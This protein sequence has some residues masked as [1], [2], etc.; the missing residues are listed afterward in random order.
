MRMLRRRRTTS[1]SVLAA[2][3][4]K[5]CSRVLR[6]KQA[7]NQMLIQSISGAATRAVTSGR[8]TELNNREALRAN[9]LL[10]LPCSSYAL[11]FLGHAQQ[12]CTCHR[13]RLDEPCPNRGPNSATI[14]T[15]SVTSCAA[16]DA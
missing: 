12:D 1:P 3:L 4:P 5:S 6:P 14:A 2:I 7:A 15:D 9:L 10:A 16:P 13:H 11:Q 8:M